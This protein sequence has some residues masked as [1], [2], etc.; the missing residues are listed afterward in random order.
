MAKKTSSRL[1][2][3]AIA[4]LRSSTFEPH[5]FTLPGQVSCYAEI[6][7]A[8]AL[9]GGRWD[10][11]SGRHVFPDTVDARASIL[12]L[13]DAGE[14]PPSNALDYYPTPADVIAEIMGN[15]SVCDAV[16]SAQAIAA[17]NERPV[18][19]LEPSAGGGALLGA[20]RCAF[21]EGAGHAV[22]FDP[23]F[24]ETLRTRFDG[25]SVHCAD[26]LKF[27]ASPDLRFDFVLMNPPFDGR[28]YQK[29]VRKAFDLLSPFGTVVAIVPEAFHTDPEFAYFAAL[30]GGAF[31]LGRD[32][33]EGT[34]IGTSVLILTNDPQN[35]W[36]EQPYNGF[37]THHAWNLD[38]SICSDAD[39][40]RRLAACKDF[41]QAFAVLEAWT[42]G[43]VRS[44]SA[45]RIDRDIAIEALV[46]LV[47]ERDLGIPDEVL[48]AEFRATFELVA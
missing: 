14:L 23:A 2:A 17:C 30:H 9:L 32:R 45:A 37:S 33:F 1:S 6:K 41:A 42:A 48:P 18:R 22:E 29:H 34:A 10:A 8:C 12:A 43:Q 19:F 35:H 24:A 46:S 5:A 31:D 20:L 27:A 28:T 16:R 25:V 4:A 39:V 3:A 15:D 36:R 38:C 7:A 44:L 21:P 47:R 13:C 40:I 11:A 26:F